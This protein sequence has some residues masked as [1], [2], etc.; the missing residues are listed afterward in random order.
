MAVPEILNLTILT[1]VRWDLK[2]HLIFVSL[3]I[4]DVE[5]FFQ[6]L[7]SHSIFLI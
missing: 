6:V 5:Y 1:G 4:K 7:V 2:V 3:M